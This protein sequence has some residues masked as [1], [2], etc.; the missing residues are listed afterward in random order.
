[1]TSQRQSQC[2]Y[3]KGWIRY[4]LVV[5]CESLLYLVFRL[6]RF[7]VFD[8]FKSLV[9]RCLGA[10]VGKRA[11]YYPGLWIMPGRNLTLGDDVDL[12]HGVLIT[13]AGGVK[14]GDRTMIGYRAQILSA[15]HV[16]PPKPQRLYDAGDIYAAVDIK[17]DA[18]IGGSSII[19]PGVTIGEGAVVAAGSVVT[20]DVPPYTIVAGCPARIIRTREAVP[21][22]SDP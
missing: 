3:E 20:K 21:S 17:N 13:T 15:N 22:D 9:L 10:E 4:N 1:M 5:L 19:L 14:I 16:I 6:P 7:S 11:I 2:M 18:W 12:A 8:A